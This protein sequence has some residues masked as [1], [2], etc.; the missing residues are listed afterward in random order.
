VARARGQLCVGQLHVVGAEAA[1]QLQAARQCGGE[2]SVAREGLQAQRHAPKLVQEV[3]LTVEH[4]Q[5][6]N[7]SNDWPRYRNPQ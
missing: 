6:A 3:A 5:I 4:A 1:Q 2:L 7:I